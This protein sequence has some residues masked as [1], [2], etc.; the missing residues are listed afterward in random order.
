MIRNKSLRP[1]ISI[2]MGML[3][4][5]VLAACGSSGGGSTTAAS[6]CASPPALAKKDHYR[7]GF[8]QNASNNPWRLA[9][10]ASIKAEAQ[11]RGDTLVYA[12]AANSGDKQ[13]S[14]VQSMIAQKV[15][16]ILLA[17][18]TEKALVPAVLQAKQACIPVILIDRDVDHTLAKPNQ[19]Y[20]TFIG[21][22]FVQQGKRVAD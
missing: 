9:E 7:V 16:V 2:L 1:G 17:P 15:D 12:D 18:I 20:V 3:L 14:D 10:T 13:V 8:S 5:I 6:S 22:D 21:S 4:C 19:D 11:K